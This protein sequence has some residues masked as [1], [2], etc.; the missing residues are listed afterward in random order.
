VSPELTAAL[1]LFGGPLLI[2]V[3]TIMF[4]RD[5][6]L[7]W[8]REPIKYWF[9]DIVRYP[10]DPLYWYYVFRRV[11]PYGVIIGLVIVISA[12]LVLA[13]VSPSQP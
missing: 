1:L 9:S 5:V 13:K 3:V 8:R 11:A 10:D 7:I 2:V 12:L 4:V 6:M